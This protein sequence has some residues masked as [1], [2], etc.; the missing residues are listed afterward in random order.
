MNYNLEKIMGHKN[1]PYILGVILFIIYLLLMRM[2][3]KI[4][5]NLTRKALVHYKVKMEG[6]IKGIKIGNYE[7]IDK[8]MQFSAVMI[9]LKVIKFI[10]F[11]IIL[12]FSLPGL[13]YFNPTT[14]ELVIKLFT[15]VSLP[16]KLIAV[17]L[18][19]AIPNFITV[20]I[21]LLCVKYLI[22]FL[23]YLAEEISSGSMRINGFYSEWAT[24]TF[25]LSKVFIYIL[26]LT[27]ISPYLPGAGSPAFRG[28]SIFA[29]I[30]VSLGSST[31][32][33]N[34]IAGFIL[35]YMRS[36]QIGD[37]IKVNE[38]TGDVVEKTVLVTRIKT[39]KNERVTV[40]NASIL[41][42][43]IINYTYSARKYN[44]IIHTSI[45]IGYDV[46]WRIV[47]RLLEEAISSVEYILK[48]PKPF[49]LQKA[50]NDFYVEYEVN[51]YTK[52]E[53]KKLKIMS[54][55]HANIQ[56]KFHAEGVEIMSPH[57]QVNRNNEDVAIPN[58]Y[59]EEK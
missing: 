48:E 50:L 33:G 23:K 4:L 27:I 45:T 26:T 55:L 19:E 37:R 38:I 57:Y 56:D 46:D 30:L 31:Y 1:Y 10:L 7:L 59:T 2:C 28:I 49:V 42:G 20:V 13:F 58:K 9:I 51:G 5:T 3:Y 32:I 17:N 41:S 11:G 36:F 12:I 39:V 52:E 8:K 14:K 54:D 22:K 53:K 40:P 24:P 15:F 16:I 6:K 29:G 35:T 25:N 21:I 18:L 44:M 34:A 43:H 47:H